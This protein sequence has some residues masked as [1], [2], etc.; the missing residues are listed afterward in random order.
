MRCLKILIIGLLLVAPGLAVAK[1][2]DV[3]G[4]AVW[5]FHVDLAQMRDDGPGRSV[6]GWLQDEVFADVRE[7]AGVDLDKELD[8]LTAFSLEGQGPVIVFEGGI[9][10]ETKDR[11]EQQ[12]A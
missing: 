7:D 1:T 10:Q 12:A 11:S 8:S 6:Y 4:S 5:Y 3:P 9:S 2:A